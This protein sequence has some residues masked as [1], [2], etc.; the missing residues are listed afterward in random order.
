MCRPD[1]E[2]LA[3]RLGIGGAIVDTGDTGLV[4]ADVVQTGLNN[5]W[6]DA[7]LGHAGCDGASDVAELPGGDLQFGIQPGLRLAPS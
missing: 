6:L 5:V 1:L 3:L 4:S 7:Q 2:G